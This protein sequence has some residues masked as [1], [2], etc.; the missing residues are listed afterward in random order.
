[1]K[2]R[3]KFKFGN[4]SKRRRKD[5]S[6]YLILCLDRALMCSP[7][8]GGIPYRGGLRIAIEQNEIFNE[9]HSSCDGYIKISFH[10][11]KDSEGK[12]QAVDFVP[13][14]KGFGY[15]YEAYGRFGILGMLMLEA[16]EELQDEGL[17]PK[18]LYLHWG[19][20]WSHKDP[21]KLGWDLAHYEIRSYPQIEKV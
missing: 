2:I 18:N 7:V 4:T 1:M 13:Y 17:I 20:L 15:S 10:Q 11:K 9:G 19:G 12:G 14:I 21:K 5:V 8:D 6:E 3:D 16:W